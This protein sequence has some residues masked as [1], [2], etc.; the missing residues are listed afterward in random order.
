M[1]T[2]WLLIFLLVT[3]GN[4]RDVVAQVADLAGVLP[5][6]RWVYEVKDEITGDL[7]RTTTVVVLNVSEK[8]INTRMSVRGAPR[9]FETVFDRNWN[10][11][12]DGI[13]KFRPSDGAGVQTPLQVGKEW[14]FENKS[15]HANGTALSTT[16]Q[17]KVVGEEK[18]T[19]S[20]GTF[21]TFK[22]ET[23]MRHVNANDQTKASTVNATLWYA[24]TV[25]RWVR[26]TNETRIEGRVRDS[27]T[28]E[29]V[30]YSRKP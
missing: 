15:T 11:I 17:S 25:N 29:L 19:T 21:D 13:W 28:E 23:R 14:R 4:T 26:R 5:G 24:P 30:D 3:F 12:D 18:V 2:K 20:A 27:H 16:G 8:E 9:P 10:R 7:K 6:D 1:S 22:I